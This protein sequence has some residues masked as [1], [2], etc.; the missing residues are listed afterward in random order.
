[1]RYGEG[2]ADAVE[3]TYGSGDKEAVKRLGCLRI[4]AAYPICVINLKEDPPI[5]LSPN[6]GAL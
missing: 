4:L 1:M 3:V 5:T 6:Q 2:N